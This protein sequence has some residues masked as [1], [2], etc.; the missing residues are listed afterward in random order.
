MWVEPLY[1][2]IRL[3]SNVR[4]F[5]SAAFIIIAGVGLLILNEYFLRIKFSVWPA[6]PYVFYWS[7]I[8]VTFSALLLAPW[9]RYQHESERL[10]IEAFMAGIF[11]GL[12]IAIY[13]VFAYREFWTLFNLLAEPIRTALF[14]L[15][16]IWV[17]REKSRALATGQIA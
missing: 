5:R 3:V 2:F 9:Q 17:L 16:V 15:L 8:A 6:I 13:K 7:I 12:A 11:V 10:M 14:G 1:K 4:L